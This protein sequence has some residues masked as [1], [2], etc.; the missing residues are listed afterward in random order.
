MVDSL[1]NTD[2][3]ETAEIR[4]F[5][6]E[7]PRAEP[8]CGLLHAFS[9]REGKDYPFLKPPPP[10]RLSREMP[11]LGQGDRCNNGPQHGSSYEVKGHEVHTCYPRTKHLRAGREARVHEG[12]LDF[13]SPS[14][15]GWWPSARRVIATTVS[16][17]SRETGPVRRSHR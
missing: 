11:A 12:R 7:I 13:F 4:P 8:I 15:H 2:N 16:A 14:H 10:R 6:I 1:P 3:Y 5:R 17:C 9:H